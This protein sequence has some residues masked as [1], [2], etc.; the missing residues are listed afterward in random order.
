MDTTNTG[1]PVIEMLPLKLHQ[2]N[3]KRHILL[4]QRE[5][6]NINTL[7][8]KQT[9]NA[10]RLDESEKKLLCLAEHL[11]K[12]TGIRC[13][14]NLFLCPEEVIDGVIAAYSDREREK[15]YKAQVGQSP[16]K[17]KMTDAEKKKIL[18]D[19]PTTSTRTSG[20]SE[21]HSAAISNVGESRGKRKDV[22][23]E[24]QQL[25]A[26][27]ST[28]RTRRKRQRKDVKKNAGDIRLRSLS[29]QMSPFKLYSCDSSCDCSLEEDI[30]QL[31]KPIYAEKDEL[32]ATDIRPTSTSTLKAQVLQ[33]SEILQKLRNYSPPCPPCY[34][35]SDSLQ[36]FLCN[37]PKKYNSTSDSLEEVQAAEELRQ[38]LI[39]QYVDSNV[40]ERKIRK[41]SN[42]GNM[43]DDETMDIQRASTS[44][45]T[46][47]LNAAQTKETDIQTGSTTT[48][49][50]STQTAS[51]G[52]S[53][54]Q[55]R[56]KRKTKNKDH[57]MAKCKK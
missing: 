32:Q 33:Q 20:T 30:F 3:I 54:T 38:Q 6:S 39:L 16:G 53:A 48:A 2:S 18:V 23:N 13:K 37:C 27:E 1:H 45:N 28:P 19:I 31:K 55:R 10:K 46:T 49:E 21:K 5:D 4:M 26:T 24:Q 36:D 56:R 8:N 7:R 15:A 25:L 52:E 35:S 11:Y 44:Q 17:S 47:T 43:Q 40:R 42:R 50:I 14:E 9:R 29:P 51:T 57:W 34:S 22:E 12:E 41:E